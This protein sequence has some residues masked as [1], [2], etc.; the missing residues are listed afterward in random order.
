MKIV[1]PGG[2]G[3]VGG[4]LTRA[5]RAAGHEV[6]II[7]RSAGVR[8]DGHTLGRWADEVDGADVVVNLAGRSVSCRYTAENLQQMM[9]SRVDSARVVGEAIAKA[10]DP[11]EVWLQMSTATI[12][13]HRF[14]APN[15]EETG[16][17]GG[18]EPDVPGYWTYSVEI[19]KRWEAELDEADT[20]G[21]RKVAL[22]A[23]MV[24]SPDKGGVFDYLS[25]MARIGLGGPV[26]GGHQYVS[27][28]HD[29][30]FVRAVALLIREP[31]AGAVNLAAPNP[32]PQREFMRELR[33]AWRVPVGLP[34]T[35]WM[36]EIGAFAIRSDTELLL[37]SRRVVPGR[38][39]QAGFE[40][41]FP[42]W[43][44]AAQNLAER[45]R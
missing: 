38:L 14:D 45:R 27:W 10:A 12:Y 13:S 26:A 22:R 32:V 24:M 7:G 41:H 4:V 35:N 25:W 42:N 6:V 15:D 9:R 23:A 17:L 11:P 44:E 36:A 19:A 40:F 34:A 8:W 28:I 31:I 1:I 33:G 37:K 29:E 43:Q 39:Q 3:Q 21:T 5:F 18:R 30:D 20:P 16:V 2:T